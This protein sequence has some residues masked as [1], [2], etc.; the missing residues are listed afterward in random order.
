M[1]SSFEEQGLKFVGQDEEGE[2]MEVV[3]LEGEHLCIWVIRWCIAQGVTFFFFKSGM[4]TRLWDQGRISVFL[5]L[6]E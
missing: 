4:T 6:T 3:E 1:K 2:R 5:S